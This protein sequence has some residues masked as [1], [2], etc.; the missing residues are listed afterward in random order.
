MPREFDLDDFDRRIID[1]L[2]IDGRKAFSEVGRAVG[3]SEGAVRNRYARL[4]R[5]GVVQVVGMADSPRIG[6]LLVHLCLRVRGVPVASVADQLARIPQVRFVALVAGSYDIV[7]D[8]TAEN[9]GELAELLNGRIHRIK[10]VYQLECSTA[11][12]TAKDSYLWAGFSEPLPTT[13]EI[14]RR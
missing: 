1:Q 10:G 7:V 11:L 12:E 14:L 5:L 2:R 6:E 4:Q 3:L 8:L 9:V 13:S